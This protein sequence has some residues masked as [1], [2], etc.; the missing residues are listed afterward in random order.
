MAQ[1]LYVAIYERDRW[2]PAWD[3]RV[4]GLPGV[5]TF[6]T[7]LVHARANVREALALWL[8][9]DEASLEVTDEIR[10][11]AATRRAVN[12]VEAARERLAAARDRL[13]H[14]TSRAARALVESGLA[15]RDA[16]ELLGLSHQRVSQ[17]LSGRDGGI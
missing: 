5:H 12:E 9:T 10:L 13:A 17:V 3:A 6:G 8:D 7:R 15:T 4:E 14:A 11:P 2:S 1:P 16:A